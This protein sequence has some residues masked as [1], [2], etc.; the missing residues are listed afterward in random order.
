V[1]VAIRVFL[2]F[3]FLVDLVLSKTDVQR[4]LD[5]RSMLYLDSVQVQIALKKRGAMVTQPD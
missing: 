2:A 4:R 5:S 1:R 3:P